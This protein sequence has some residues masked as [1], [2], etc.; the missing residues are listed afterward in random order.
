[1]IA[2]FVS[3]LLL[4]NCIYNTIRAIAPSKILDG[5]APSYN[6]RQYFQA[7]RIT[8]VAIRPISNVSGEISYRAIVEDHQ[9]EVSKQVEGVRRSPGQRQFLSY[10]TMRMEAAARIMN[11]PI[12]WLYERGLAIAPNPRRKPLT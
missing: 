11:S 4:I 7:K 8:T 9:M 12:Q 3:K 6:L 5:I 2:L 10:S 1:V